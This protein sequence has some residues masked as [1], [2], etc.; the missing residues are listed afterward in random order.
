MH[1]IPRPAQPAGQSPE[2]PVP[3]NAGLALDRKD[4]GGKESLF[5]LSKWV[6]PGKNSPVVKGISRRK[7]RS[8]K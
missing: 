3:R 1:I 8:S 2:E 4:Q 5:R 6:N 7:K